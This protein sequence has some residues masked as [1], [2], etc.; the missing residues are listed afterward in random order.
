MHVCCVSLYILNPINV[1]LEKGLGHSPLHGITI[2]FP[3]RTTDCIQD[4]LFSSTLAGRA[5]QDRTS[6]INVLR[7]TRMRAY[8]QVFYVRLKIGSLGGF[9]QG[10]LGIWVGHNG[11]N[12]TQS[13]FRKYHTGMNRL[14]DTRV[15]NRPVK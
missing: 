8:S 14:K 5:P 6:H 15:R 11:Y 13:V 4:D 10:K 7:S 12:M 1:L 2:P 3:A 9:H